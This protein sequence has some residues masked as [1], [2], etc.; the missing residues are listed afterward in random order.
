MNI[1]FSF[2]SGTIYGKERER[3]GGSKM[4]LICDFS[5]VALCRITHT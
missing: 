3:E 5:N 1:D 4:G 2:F